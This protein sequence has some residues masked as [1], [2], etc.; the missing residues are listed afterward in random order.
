M[1]QLIDGIWSDEDIISEIQADGSYL[2]KP[3]VFRNF[4]TADGASGFKAES[5]RYHLYSSTGCPWAHRTEL[6]RALKNLTE[7]ITLHETAQNPAGGGWWFEGVN[8]IVPGTDVTVTHLHEIYALADPGYSGKVSVPTLWDA[9]EKTIVNNESS[10]IIRMFNSEFS[11]VAPATPDLCPPDLMGKIDEMNKLI[12]NGVNDAVNGCGRS[13]SQQAYEESFEI[14]FSTFDKLENILAS[15]RYLCG[16]QLTES[17]LRLYP[18]F[19][20]FDS[21]YYLGYK[22]NKRRI[23]DYPNLSAY[24]RDL[25]QTPGISD[26][27]NIELMKKRIYSI[28]GPIATNGIV[29]KGPELGL[30]RP[31]D[32]EKL[33]TAA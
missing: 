21:I 18:T 14:L 15:Q 13:K 30:D 16:N 25:Y 27:S 1:G 4:I 11:M 24:L 28:G 20:R 22:C 7:V 23:E 10:E 6:F 26:V 31:H 3:S 12:L 32:R 29:P 9:Q 8:H 17:D 33:S 19:L 2:K 5:G